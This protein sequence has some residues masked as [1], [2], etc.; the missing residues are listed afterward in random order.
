MMSIFVSRLRILAVPVLLGLGLAGFA[1]TSGQAKTQ[2]PNV[3]GINATSNGGMT[4][5]QATFASDVA[6]DGSYQLKVVSSGP[7]GNS[8]I[9]QGGQFTAA[10]HENLTLGQVS[11]N[12]GS[13]YEIHFKVTVGGAEMDCS[14]TI[15]SRT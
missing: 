15:P 14:Q 2:D 11:I 5:L 7:G 10:A 3:C 8:N 6:V 9:S 12:D 13:T 1:A 4:A